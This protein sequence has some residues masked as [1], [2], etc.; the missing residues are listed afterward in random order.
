MD[1]ETRTQGKTTS[2]GACFVPPPS[3]FSN[4]G[5]KG[6]GS[7]RS[8]TVNAPVVELE[9]TDNPLQQKLKVASQSNNTAHF[10]PS[11]N[12]IIEQSNASVDSKRAAQGLPELNDEPAPWY[13]RGLTPRII[14]WDILAGVCIGFGLLFLLP[15]L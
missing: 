4:G 10:S 14:F 7:S 12:E 8:V 15:I 5:F 2:A 1:L 6:F 3:N 13:R 9:E 11:I